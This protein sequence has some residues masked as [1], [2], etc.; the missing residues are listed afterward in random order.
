[1]FKPPQL[2]GLVAA[3][4]A[5]SLLSA[6]A[7]KAFEV[8][9]ERPMHMPPPPPPP[10]FLPL[11]IP[12]QDHADLLYR[13]KLTPPQEALLEKAES[14]QAMLMA[15]GHYK[16]RKQMESLLAALADGKTPVAGVLRQAGQLRRAELQSQLEV[17]GFWLAFLDSLDERQSHFV[18]GF[19]LHRLEMAAPMRHMGAA[20]PMAARPTR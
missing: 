3:L 17:E 2:L 16:Q 10:V 12:G 13:L 1:M 18:R 11:M 7:A 5:T 8:A 9:P 20:S 19:I 14:A 6:P 4:V 15:T